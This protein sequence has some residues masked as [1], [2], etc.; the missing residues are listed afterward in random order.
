[1]QISVDVPEEYVLDESPAELGRKL[2]L[3]TALLMFQSGEISAGGATQLA[4][5][6]RFT[7]AAECA[8]PGIAL[9]D[10]PLSDLRDEV[11]SLRRLP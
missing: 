8:R 6:D 3:Y 4:G 7:F 9:V 1:M 2:K 5:V 11:E 10:Y